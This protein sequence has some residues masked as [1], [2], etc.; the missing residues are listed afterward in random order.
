MVTRWRR[1]KSA[2]GRVS[3]MVTLW[4]RGNAGGFRFVGVGARQACSTGQMLPSPKV[5][6]VDVDDTLIRTFGT[7]QI[8]ISRAVEYVRRK[9]AEGC[10]LYLWSRGGG[11]YAREVASSLGIADLFQTFL[12]KPDVVF[13]DR[14]ESFLEHCACVHPNEA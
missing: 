2:T 7:K 13:D 10:T 14:T 6:Y 1:C 12:P 4:T 9:H 8:P 5:I 11:D 3:R